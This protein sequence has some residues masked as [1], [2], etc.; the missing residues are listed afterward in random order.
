MWSRRRWLARL[1]FSF[2]IIAGVLAWQAIQTHRTA[3]DAERWRAWLYAVAAG[4]GF[5]LFVAGL[6]ARHAAED[7][8]DHIKGPDEL[9]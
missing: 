7:H 4:L 3:P 9:P 5:M 2:L 8:E 1:T 6:R